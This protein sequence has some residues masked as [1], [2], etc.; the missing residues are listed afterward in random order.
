M[1]GHCYHLFTPRDTF[2][3]H[4]LHLSAASV[5]DFRG[6]PC[7]IGSCWMPLTSN[8]EHLKPRFALR[9]FLETT[10]SI[11]STSGFWCGFR[12]E[13]FGFSNLSSIQDRR[14]MLG[15][16]MNNLNR[17]LIIYPFIHQKG[18]AFLFS[19]LVTRQEASHCPGA[20][21]PAHGP[22]GWTG[23]SL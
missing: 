4:T 15:I 7:L 9:R 21:A 3:I 10:I 17:F 16:I 12:R 14:T 13:R 19:T 20:S 11:Y 18:M 5:F 22:T 2:Q 8:F 6:I 23:Q 1:T